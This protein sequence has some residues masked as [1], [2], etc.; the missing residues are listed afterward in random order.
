MN[1]DLDGVSVNLCSTRA[2]MGHEEVVLPMLV[3]GSSESGKKEAIGTF[4]HGLSDG[5]SP[6]DLS[7]TA[8]VGYAAGVYLLKLDV[9]SIFVGKYRD[10]W[11]RIPEVAAALDALDREYAFFLEESS[12][13]LQDAFFRRCRLV[14]RSRLQDF[15][16]DA[17]T[18][19]ETM[20][21]STAAEVLTAFLGHSMREP[22]YE[23]I[24]G[25]YC[26]SHECYRLYGDGDQ[27][28]LGY[29]I[30]LEQEGVVRAWTR[31][32]YVPR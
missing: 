17:N 9:K 3:L 12:A 20:Q 13:P 6:N 14:S 18:Q 24:Y 5:F 28:S 7:N 1:T 11:T 29:A 4:W 23:R 2:F 22:C 21:T 31:I 30:W 25:D 19:A 16:P 10:E 15:H 8:I 27:F 26:H 32:T